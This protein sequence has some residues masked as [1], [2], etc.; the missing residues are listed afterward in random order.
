M[1]NNPSF[2]I[3]GVVISFDNKNSRESTSSSSPKTNFNFAFAAK[4]LEATGLRKTDPRLKQ[5][6]K[7][8]RDFQEKSANKKLEDEET[9]IGRKEFKE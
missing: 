5:M 9:V 3:I 7:H 1:K 6:M 4:A 2:K 8:L